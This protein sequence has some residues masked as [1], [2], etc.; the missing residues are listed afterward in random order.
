M[1]TNTNEEILN[2]HGGLEKI[3]DTNKRTLLHAAVCKNF[4]GG[5]NFLLSLAK[6]KLDE[7]QKV[8]FVNAQDKF[9][10]TALHYAV[11][12]KRV[13]DIKCLLKEGANPT[14]KNRHGHP[15]IFFI[16]LSGSKHLN[17]IQKEIKT[18]LSS[19]QPENK[20]G[21]DDYENSPK[22]SPK[23]T[24][25]IERLFI[26]GNNVQV[27]GSTNNV[28]DSTTSSSTPSFSESEP[29]FLNHSPQSSKAL[30]IGTSMQVLGLF[31]SAI[32]FSAVAVGILLSAFSLGTL[33]TAGTITIIS[34]A[35]MALA[36]IGMFATGTMM[37]D[38]A[39]SKQ[40]P[41]NTVEEKRPQTPDIDV[42]NVDNLVLQ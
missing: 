35:S 21:Q 4:P 14:I 7:K 41:L 30:K 23:S 18:L 26:K 25:E 16:S 12:C 2:K 6:E 36:G 38:C 27:E 10:H 33:S 39:A 31:A 3:I 20:I 34:G 42:N 28:N 24:E 40:A 19:H 11:I 9:G 32:G 1:T 17:A 8:E 5:V 37:K 22:K 29:D 13:G 15:P